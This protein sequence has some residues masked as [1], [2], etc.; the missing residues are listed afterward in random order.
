MAFYRQVQVDFWKDVKVNEEMTPEDKLFYLYLLTNPDTTQIGIYTITKKKMAYDIGY[1]V[2]TIQT[3]L[4]RFE[5][6]HKLIKYNPETREVVLCN[7]GKYNLNRAGK[8]IEDCVKKE[9][10]GVKDKS[11]IQH[12]VHTIKNE[13]IRQLFLVAVPTKADSEKNDYIE[14]VQSTN[15]H[16]HEQIEQLDQSY[17]KRD[18]ALF[19]RGSYDTST[20][21]GTVRGQKQKQTQEQ[22]Q[23]SKD[24]DHPDGR[25]N[26]YPD[27]FEDFWSLYPRRLGKK[28]AFSLWERRIKQDATQED[29]MQAVQ[30]YAEYCEEKKLEPEYIK[31][32]STFL[33]NKLDY[34]DWITPLVRQEKNVQE[35]KDYV[36]IRMQQ[37]MAYLNYLYGEEELL[38][39]P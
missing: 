18:E 20:I 38:C 25:S 4:D 28:R 15:G 21:R 27:E 17:E 30:N 36:E 34:E 10:Q 16:V 12:V 32:P 11:L 29:L 1:S 23:K 22:K 33:S 37:D 14:H 39:N 13:K 3:L 6:Y 24:K 9:L 26:V 2:E 5:Q 7:W 35:P 31:H 8:P 19:Y